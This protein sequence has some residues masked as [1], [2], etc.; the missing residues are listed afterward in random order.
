MSL[1]PFVYRNILSDPFFPLSSSTHP[2]SSSSSSS[3]IINPSLTSSSTTSGMNSGSNW[4]LW[5]RHPSELFHQLERSYPSF[6]DSTGTQFQPLSL[7]LV[8]L[9]D[10]FIFTAGIFISLNYY[11][12][13]YFN[14]F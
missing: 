10:K 1:A 3:N 5:N 8:E 4:D 12:N 11:F 7:D 13:Y 6:W 2:S 14:Y 9:A